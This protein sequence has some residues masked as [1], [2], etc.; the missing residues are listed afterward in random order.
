MVRFIT[1][2]IKDIL[3]FSPDKVTH[4][5]HVKRVLSRP[6]K[7][8]LYVKREKCEFYMHKVTFLRYVIGP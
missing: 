6:L 8:Q 5:Q 7:H 1:A 3:I 4:I 2:Y